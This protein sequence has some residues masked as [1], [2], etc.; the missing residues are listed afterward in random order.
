M[1]DGFPVNAESV[2]LIS[3]LWYV[4]LPNDKHPESKLLPS[5]LIIHRTGSSDYEA[6]LKMVQVVNEWAR[7]RGGRPKLPEK[8]VRAYLNA[9]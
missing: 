4:V 2:R 8:N 5:G 6:A 7:V 3:G 9:V 1:T